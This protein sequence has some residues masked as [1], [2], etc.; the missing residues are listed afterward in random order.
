MHV[1]TC[2]RPIPLPAP[3][4]QSGPFCSHSVADA[5]PL[6]ALMD[7]KLCSGDKRGNHA[8][9]PTRAAHQRL[10]LAPRILH[11]A[12]EERESTFRWRNDVAGFRS[13]WKSAAPGER[14]S[15]CAVTGPE[16]VF[17]QRDKRF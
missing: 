3:P 11:R 10:L 6:A 16:R 2:Q 15:R 14:R 5:P 13:W 1:L 7:T 4:T 8:P 12:K 9:R 17:N